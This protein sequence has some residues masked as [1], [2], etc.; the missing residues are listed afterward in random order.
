MRPPPASTRTEKPCSARRPALA[1]LS[2][3]IV[4]RAEPERDTITYCPPGKQGGRDGVPP[5]SPMEEE[6]G[7]VV[8]RATLQ[9]VPLVRSLSG[10]SVAVAVVGAGVLGSHRLQASGSE[11]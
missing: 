8:R 5:S 7:P 11:C 1:S 3:R 4:S 9:R 6:A 10:S 2:T